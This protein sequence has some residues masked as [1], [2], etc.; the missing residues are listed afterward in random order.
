MEG[1]LW[2]L[3]G[4]TMIA[5]IY[6]IGYGYTGHALWIIVAGTI[7]NLADSVLGAAWERK[8]KL[9]NDLV[10]GLNTIIAAIVIFLLTI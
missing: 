5:V 4:S 7:G 3:A 6:S 9:T 10:N 8:G 1:T 2:G